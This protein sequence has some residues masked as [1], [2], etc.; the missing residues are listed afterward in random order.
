MKIIKPGIHFIITDSAGKELEIIFSHREDGKYV[1]GVTSE[2]ILE[3]ML[4]RQR[5]F[6]IDKEKD[7]KENLSLLI[8]IKQ[9]LQFAR[10]INWLKG[11][12]RKQQKAINP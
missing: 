9:A 6:T 7:T 1:D 3:V 8:H 11:Q 4:E 10:Q 12:T 5:Y 2:Q